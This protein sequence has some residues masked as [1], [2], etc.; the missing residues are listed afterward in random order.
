MDNLITLDNGLALLEPTISMAIATYERKL[1]ELK[2][3]EDDLKKMI[4]AEM[5]SKSIIKIDTPELTISYIAP[6]DR[7]SFDSKTF[8]KDHADLYDDYVKMTPVKSSI[9]I[10]VKE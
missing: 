4:L 7:E 10:K 1:K 2:T 9:R 5:E 3:A 6:T 8:K